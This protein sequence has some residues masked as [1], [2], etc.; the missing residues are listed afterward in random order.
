M[1]K[2][3]KVF[4]IGAGINGL[5][6]AWALV[7]RGYEVEVFERGG[8]PN[9]VSSSYD[10]HRITRHAYGTMHAY[11]DKMP[12]AFRLWEQLFADIGARHLDERPQILFQ[13][14]PEPWVD[15]SIVDLDRFGLGW[16]DLSLGEVADRYP[17]IR[18]DGMTRAV[19]IDGSGILFPI[20]ILT[21]L[22]VHLGA[23]GVTFHQSADVSDIDPE[24]ARLTVGGTVHEADHLVIAAGAW[25]LRLLPELAGEAT[26]SRQAVL[27]LS[28]PVELAAAWREAP[29]FLDLG[30]DST[31]YM[32]P[33]RPGT[34]LK[35]GDHIFTRQGDPDAPRVATDEDCA[36]LMD[37]GTRALAGFDRYTILER[38]ACYYTVTDTEDFVIRPVGGKATVV[39]ACSGHGFKL[40]PHS[41]EEAARLVDA[42]G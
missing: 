19:S 33:P 22:V 8:I 18:M 23:K 13:R 15:A 31:T 14:G 12:E 20:R 16:R 2:S 27:F 41:G 7:R 1:S 39:S 5:C 26:P 37:Y 25:V 30:N 32:L 3:K 24:N 28:P 21:D 42:A 17:M 38:K 36:R 29:I 4:V 11:A 6:T 34:R 40:A 9:L 10:E 35:I